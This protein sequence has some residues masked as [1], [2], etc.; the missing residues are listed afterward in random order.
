MYVRTCTY[1]RVSA[2]VRACVCVHLHVTRTL[3]LFR[4]QLSVLDAGK[5]KK[6]GCYSEFAMATSS[7]CEA[8]ETRESSTFKRP[9]AYKFSADNARKRCMWSHATRLV[10]SMDTS[11]GISQTL[12][13]A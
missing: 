13:K 11:M 12:N 10:D 5:R 4:F 2:C 6:G 7:N 3:A 8:H 9:E 1:V